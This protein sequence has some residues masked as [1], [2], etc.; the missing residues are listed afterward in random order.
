MFNILAS[1]VEVKDYENRI[2]HSFLCSKLDIEKEITA[3]VASTD[4][5]NFPKIAS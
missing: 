4:K 5:T 3:A 1:L 2:L